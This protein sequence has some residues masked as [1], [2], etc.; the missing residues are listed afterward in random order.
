M[1]PVP[2][3]TPPSPPAIDGELRQLWGDLEVEVSRVEVRTVVMPFYLD[4]RWRLLM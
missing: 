3:A 4:P 1:T 2:G